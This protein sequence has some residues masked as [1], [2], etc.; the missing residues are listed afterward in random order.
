ML[1]NMLKRKYVMKILQDVRIQ[2][3]RLIEHQRPDRVVMEK[4]AK[5]A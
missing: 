4:T 5:N 3:D 2:M 1:E